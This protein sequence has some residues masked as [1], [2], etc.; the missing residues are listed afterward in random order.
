[1]TRFEL[2]IL[3]GNAEMESPEDVAIALRSLA[4]RFDE[5]G[6]A[7]RT[8]IWDANGNTVGKWVAS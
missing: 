4:A 7:A 8:Y 5:Q 6:W 3:L 1:M 2:F